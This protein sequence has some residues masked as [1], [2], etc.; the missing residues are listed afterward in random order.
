[1]TLQIT[2]V[3]KHFKWERHYSYLVECG[4]KVNKGCLF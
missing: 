1:M 2:E 4:E 3:I